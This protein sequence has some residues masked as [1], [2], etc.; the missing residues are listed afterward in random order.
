MIQLA[1]ALVPM[2]IEFFGQEMLWVLHQAHEISQQLLLSPTVKKQVVIGNDQAI[3]GRCYDPIK[4]DAGFF[5]N[6]KSRPS[7]AIQ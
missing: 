4:S 6:N 1:P 7:E 2:A 3:F 5:L